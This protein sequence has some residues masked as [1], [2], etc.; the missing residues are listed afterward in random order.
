MV[1]TLENNGGGKKQKENTRTG[2]KKHS[3]RPRKTW[4]EK[5]KREIESSEEKKWR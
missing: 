2:K 3:G 1:W 4:M 5:V